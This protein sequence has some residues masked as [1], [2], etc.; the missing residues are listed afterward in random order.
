MLK[1]LRATF[2]RNKKRKHK[3]I[4]RS[5]DHKQPEKK[6]PMPTFKRPKKLLPP[7]KVP[8]FI[9]TMP[10]PP[11][12]SDTCR[13]LRDFILSRPP[14][15]RLIETAAYESALLLIAERRIS[16]LRPGM[17]IDPPVC[18]NERNCVGVTQRLRGFEGW[19]EGMPLMSYLTHAE[20]D[21]LMKTG[22][23]PSTRRPCL[24]CYRYQLSYLILALSQSGTPMHQE[25]ELPSFYNDVG[26]GEYDPNFCHMPGEYVYIGFKRPCAAFRL[27]RLRV[28]RDAAGYRYVSQDEMLQREGDFRSGTTAAMSSQWHSVAE[29][30]SASCP[31]FSS[32]SMASPPSPKMMPDSPEWPSSFDWPCGLENASGSMDDLQHQIS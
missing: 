16:P 13:A 20:Y 23:N 21:T 22:I 26:P 19:E 18:L 27:D 3:H 17:L 10:Q 5:N 9:K 1:K 2:E 30:T 24:L 6:E 8:T 11:P 29:G 14:A 12:T 25:M 7:T 32:P 4:T 15:T 31:G 28:R